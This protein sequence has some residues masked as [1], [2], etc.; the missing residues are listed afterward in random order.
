MTIRST[1]NATILS[2][3]KWWVVNNTGIRGQSIEWVKTT[4]APAG[5][6]K[7]DIDAR[8]AGQSATPSNAFNGIHEP[9]SP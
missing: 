3:S 6:E 5:I 8:D 1:V 7:R 2:T 9:Q 4:A